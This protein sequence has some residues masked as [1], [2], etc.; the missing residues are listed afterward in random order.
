MP[1]TFEDND[2]QRMY[3][4]WADT[5][6]KSRGKGITI[7]PEWEDFD[8]FYRDM[9][10]TY[11]AGLTLDRID[12]AGGYEPGSCQWLSKSEHAI[13]SNKA[14]QSLSWYTIWVSVENNLYQPP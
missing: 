11:Q 6:K 14:C 2:K 4:S 3:W 1:R 8:V 7:C 12:N 10:P 13:K 5:R 9:S